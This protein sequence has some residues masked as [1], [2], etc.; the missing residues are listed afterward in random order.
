MKRGAP[1]ALA[2]LLSAGVAG[3]QPADSDCFSREGAVFQVDRPGEADGPS[4]IPA[5]IVQFET[6]LSVSRETG[7]D[8]EPD[9]DSY[10]V[11]NLLLR[12]GVLRQLELRVSADGFVYQD[13][14]GASNRAR[15]SDFDI[16]AK[17]QLNCPELW[18]PAFGTIVKL[19]FPTG[20]AGVTSDGFD[21]TV[22][23]LMDFVIHNDA[24]LTANFDFSAPTQGV[25]DDRRIFAFEPQ[26]S[27]DFD[28]HA[29][30]GTY[31]EYFGKVQT[32]GVEDEHSVGG[33][34]RFVRPGRFQFD[35]GASGGVNSG[36]PEWTITAGFSFRF[37]G[38]GDDP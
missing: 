34:F 16:G 32:G 26:F 24:V 12:L 29:N 7:D 25:D 35:L 33:G 31:V 13:R 17:F 9:V 4:V 37:Q 27:L 23:L 11:P 8:D 38:W 6:G 28:L 3:A 14:G 1:L 36:A 18:R 20:S 19:S 22:E 30:F 10:T 15:G 21:P 2:G 5:G